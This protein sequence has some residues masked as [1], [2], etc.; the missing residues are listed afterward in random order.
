[1][2]RRNVI[3]MATGEAFW[4][5]AM[6]MVLSST[7][8]TVFLREHGAGETMIGSISSIESGA[9]VMLQFTGLFLFASRGRRKQQA[10]GWH[11]YAMIPFLFL[12]GILA[13]ASSRLSSAAVRW[14]AL[15]LYSGFAAAA[16]VVG[17]AFM[18]WLAHV[19]SE[20]V[21]GTALGISLCVSGLAGMGGSLLAGWL[22][23]L[24]PSPNPYA[25]LYFG[26]GVLA[27]IGILVYWRL[28]DAGSVG[29]EDAPRP[30]RED[31]I[32]Y[33]RASLADRN[34]RCFLVSRILATTGF[35]M[36]P[37]IAV[38]YTSPEGGAFSDGTVVSYGAAMA[39][40]GAFSNLVFGRLGDR[41][42]HAIGLLLGM[43]IQVTTLAVLVWGR[44][45]WSCLAAYL[46]AGICLGAGV[47]SH[48]NAL[49]ETC[50][51]DNR[52]AHITVGNFVIGLVGMAAPVLGGMA[53]ARWGVR[54]LFLICLVFSLIALVWHAFFV[55]EPRRDLSF[56]EMFLKS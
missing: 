45:M 8:L 41:Q 32:R 53:A 51:H 4:G 38:Q 56:T 49:M 35:C 15:I 31:V 26:S 46:G 52:F 18:D 25:Y 44:G 37:F 9:G 11:L 22:I 28:D 16:G 14:G 27:V 17:A 50:P 29:M 24:Q 2:N 7:V 42:G 6:A 43:I 34:F 5:L 47:V 36:V 13:C 23:R 33:I 10:L 20:R 40:G 54:T 19:F 30:G 1:M 3:S 21:R 12:I 48:Y 55:R 39:V